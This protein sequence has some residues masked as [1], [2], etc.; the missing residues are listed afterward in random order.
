MK[1][2]LYLK[3]GLGFV[4]SLISL[5]AVSQQTPST[6]DSNPAPPAITEVDTNAPVDA[7]VTPVPSERPVPT[8]VKLS[9][10]ASELVRL[11]NSGLEESVLLAYVTNSTSTFNLGAEEII[12]LNDIGVPS[13]VVTAM[14][15]H[16]Q[17]VRGATAAMIAA[18]TPAPAP[19]QMTEP[20]PATP[21]QEP[22][23]A[24]GQPEAAPPPAEAPLT[25]PETTSDFYGTLAPYGSWVNVDGYGPCWQPTVVVVNPLWQPYCDGGHWVY[26]DCGWYWSS[27]Y[28]WGWFSWCSITSR[29]AS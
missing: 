8:K 4:L 5:V 18:N 19:Q 28:S 11:A 27:G 2:G 16:D 29:R 23:P 25:P 14:I 9:I 20:P 17:T 7:P 26:T 12:Y 15:H 3:L 13:A 21:A 10:P 6:P 24:E 22:P 1:S